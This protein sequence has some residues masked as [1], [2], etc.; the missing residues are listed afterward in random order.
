VSEWIV[1]RNWPK[2]QHY[3][4]REPVWIKL[5][6]DLRSRD[7]WRQLTLAERGLLVSIWLEYAASNGQIRRTDLPARV[8]QRS[9]RRSIDSLQAAGFIEVS[10]SRPLALARAREEKEKETPKSPLKE[11]RRRVT[12]W[13]EVKGSHGTTTIPDPFGTDRAPVR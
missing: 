6:L 8:A 13:R 11:K 7:E 5:Y 9:L 12:G 10:A 4:D 1:V 3:K 2:F